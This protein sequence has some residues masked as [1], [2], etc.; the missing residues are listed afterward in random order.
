MTKKRF[1]INNFEEIVCSLALFITIISIVINIV[2][3]AVTGRRYGQLEEISIVG[4]VWVTFMGVSAVYKYN[5]HICIDF[6]VNAFP[7]RVQDFI[8]LLIY[9]LLILFDAYLVSVAWELA[10]SA[11]E[12]TTPLLGI[13][14]FFIDL[15]VVIGFSCMAI[16]TIIDLVR[17]I[18]GFRS[19]AK[20][21]HS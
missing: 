15:S 3:G 12:K 17:K 2:L 10:L 7:K 20:E 5:S 16:R 1:S 19:R 11:T 14:Y 9:V 13:S 4:F 8:D 6:L 18:R 21:D